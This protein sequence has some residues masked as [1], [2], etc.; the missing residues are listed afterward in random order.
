MGKL[1]V[2][3]KILIRSIELEIPLAQIAREAGTTRQN[4]YH[5]LAGRS[6]SKRIRK[7]I[8][9]RLRFAARDLGWP[10]LNNNQQAA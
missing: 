1:T 10:E 5:V 9:Q 8:C 2:K 4:V 7:L 6:R 3:K